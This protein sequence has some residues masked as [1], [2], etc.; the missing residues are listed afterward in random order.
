MEN[1]GGQRVCCPPLPLKLLGGPGPPP[2]PPPP[3]SYAYAN[4]TPGIL[5][6]TCFQRNFLSHAKSISPYFSKCLVV[7]LNV[8]LFTIFMMKMGCTMR[9]DV[10]ST[11]IQRYYVDS[12]LIGHWFG[13]MYQVG[14]HTPNRLCLSRYSRPK[15]LKYCLIQYFLYL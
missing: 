5:W 2:P 6:C 7:S 4:V 3:S 13:V 1:W 12:A 9:I 15:I 11:F 10:K 14:K 8:N